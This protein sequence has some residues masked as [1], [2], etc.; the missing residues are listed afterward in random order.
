MLGAEFKVLKR[1]GKIEVLEQWINPETRRSTA[2]SNQSL[3][4][5]TNQFLPVE[6]T[7]D[8]IQYQINRTETGWVVELVNNKGMAKKPDQPA[9]IDPQAVAHVT[10]KP[11]TRYASAVQWQSRQT[12][13]RPKQIEVTLGPGSSEFVEFNQ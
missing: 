10:L 9:A 3:R 2:I 1:L 8:P 7:G 11:A 5:I 6:V 13:Q 4:R 12:H